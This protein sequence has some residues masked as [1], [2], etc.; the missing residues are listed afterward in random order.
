[1]KQLSYIDRIKVLMLVVMT[2]GH[3]AWAFVPIDTVLSDV[4]HFFARMTIPLACFLVV[5]GFQKTHD[6]TGYIKR[7]FGFAILAQVPFMA[8]MVLVANKL[9]DDSFITLSDVVARPMTLLWQGNVLFSLGFALLALLAVNTLHTTADVGHKF[10]ALISLPFLLLLSTW[11]DWSFLVIVWVIAI[12]YG[13]AVGF[14]WVSVAAIAVS[15]LDPSGDEQSLLR[16]LDGRQV[17]DYGVFLTV[18]IMYW[19][20]KKAHL[21]PTAYR[22]PRLLFYWY[23]VGHLMAL[24]AVLLAEYL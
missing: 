22:L 18:P 14:F 2:L 23:Y 10:V 1:M 16:V 4:L 24:S 6:L 20:D 17:M 11:S 15:W 5:M 7:M 21:S 13:R 19:Y 9:Y 8:Y 12:W 3:I